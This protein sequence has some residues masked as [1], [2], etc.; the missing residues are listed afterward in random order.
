[1]SQ[2]DWFVTAFEIVVLLLLPFHILARR[3]SPGIL[4][5]L[6]VVS[7]LEI[8]RTNGEPVPAQHNLHTVCM[9]FLLTALVLP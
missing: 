6:A 4:A 2:F 1:M 5:L 3:S 7:V 8:L 9:F